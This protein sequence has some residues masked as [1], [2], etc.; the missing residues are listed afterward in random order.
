[1]KDTQSE[2]A[3]KSIKT[4]LSTYFT[5][6]FLDPLFTYLRGVKIFS[7]A[8]MLLLTLILDFSLWLAFL[9]KVIATI[10]QAGI[11]VKLIFEEKYLHLR[12]RRLSWQKKLIPIALMAVG[13]LFYIEKTLILYSMWGQPSGTLL[14]PYRAYSTIFF[15][16]SFSIYALR[17]NI[18]AG[19]LGRL[20]LKPAQTLAIGFIGMILFG[21]LVLSLP[22]VVLDPSKVS[23]V[24]ALFTATS[25]STVTGLVLYPISEYYRP[26]GLWVI[27]FLIQLG[28]IGIMTFGVLFSLISHQR[29]RL[30][31]EVALQGVL[32]T[33]SI[34][35]VKKEIKLIFLITFTIEAL[36]A[37]LIWAMTSE[38]TDQPLFSA[39][40]H[41]IS[42]FCNA[43][44]SLF[45]DNL[46]GYAHNIPMNLIIAVL[47]V[48]GG[49][50]F[51]VLNNLG[52]YPF[53]KKERAEWR[54][55]FHSKMV[56]SISVG[57]LIVGT[58]GIYILEFRGTLDA[59]PWYEKWVA[60]AFHSVTART[61]GFNTLDTGAY[62]DAALFL[63]ILLMWIGGSPASTAGG[64]KTTTFG[65]MLATLGAMLHR[66][67]EVSL[68][69]RSLSPV[70]V[71][72]SLSIAFTSSALLAFLLLLLLATEE[73]SFKEIVFESVSAFNTV[74]L[75]TGITSELSTV[76]KIIITLTMFIGRIGPLTLAFSLAERASKGKLSY[77][78]E[79]VIIG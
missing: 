64:I 4:K 60:A 14:N 46:E 36:G 77:P 21:T 71:H 39:I 52:N 51:P 63:I 17:I 24:D 72:K 45:P 5:F 32:E 76:G 66:R 40:F 3:D 69:K 38:A 20:K 12:F 16:S 7:T 68:F 58:V 28:G 18:I 79:R 8:G 29:M 9:S 78:Q 30:Q 2:K 27:L 34:G 47:I 25:A 31:H 53:F 49:I 70:A 48:L 54:L 42:A 26:S 61:A 1:M 19:F 23:I 15:A 44:F 35:T 22:Q 50:G 56:L 59:L 10:L 75:S 43:G 73:G 13:L 41:S 33:E 57:L 11:L 62:S 55:S 6:R 67:E 37:V 74:G 65:V